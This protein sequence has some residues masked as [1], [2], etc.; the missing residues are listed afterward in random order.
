MNVYKILTF[1]GYNSVEYVV[2]G[3]DMVSAIQSNGMIIQN[4]IVKSELVGSQT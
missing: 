2:Y 4:Q 3:Y 1:D